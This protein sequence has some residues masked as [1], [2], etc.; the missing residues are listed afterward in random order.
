MAVV[1]RTWLLYLFYNKPKYNH[2]KNFVITHVL[3]GNGRRNGAV[4]NYII[5][6]SAIVDT[7]LRTVLIV[8]MA[9]YYRG[10]TVSSIGAGGGI[11]NVIKTY[12]SVVG[13][14]NF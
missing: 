5:G 6:S 12:L 14:M 2:I 10:L 11:W 13:W 7:N 4:V 3:T 1:E 8:W 9:L